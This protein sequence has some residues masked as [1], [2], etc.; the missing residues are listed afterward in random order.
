MYSFFNNQFLPTDKT[1]IHVSDLATQRG[2]GIFDFLKAV[3][4]KPLFIDDYLDRFYRSA[5]FMRLEVSQSREEL[6]KIIHEL[7][8]KN[9]LTDS[10]IKLILTGGYSPDGYELTTPN[11]I[12]TL[13]ALTMPSAE[14]LE[15]GIKII[16]HEYVR[17]LPHVKSINYIMGVWL[18]N[19]VKEEKAADALYYLNGQVSEFPRCNIFIVRDDGVLVTPADRVLHGITRKNI[20]SLSGKPYTIQE[21][22]V[23]MQELLTAK[24]VFLTSTTKRIVPI[25]KVNEAVI[26]NGRPG[27]V[28]QH[29]LKDLIQLE[30]D[31]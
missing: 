11:L 3:N 27:P 12:I 5:A 17:D 15:K 31:Y 13:H 24:E 6:K 1:F 7:I 9:G 30:L 23:S 22:T 26:G 18:Q 19:L 25:V 10:G 21:G 8:G 14:Y 4:G 29:L 20:L 16:T 28:T 2:Y